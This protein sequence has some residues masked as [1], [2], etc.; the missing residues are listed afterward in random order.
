MK[1]P[2]INYLIV[3]SKESFLR[4]PL[5]VLSS[6][7]SVI[8]G[9][10]LIEF[11]D[12]IENPF[13]YINLLL[14]TA[15]GIPLYFCVSIFITKKN[16]DFKL[17][18]AS[19]TLG[20]TIL[21]LIY[22]SLPDSE[23]T[24]NTSLPYIRYGLYNII[25]HLL[26]S[27][28]PYAKDMELNGFWNYNKIL[29]IRFWT[30]LLYSGFL[31][32]GITLALVSL[33]ILFNIEIPN[34]LYFKIS[35]FILGFFNTWF[36]V[37]GIPKE[38]DNLEN[39]KEYPEGLKVFTQYILLP[40]L[41]L[42]LVILYT[43][44]AKILISWDW[45]KG[46]V[47]YLISCVSIL[48]ILTL[49]L[50]HPYGNLKE[51]SWVKKFTN[52]YYYI[53]FPL[54]IILFIAIWFRINDYGITINRYVIILLGVWLSIISFYFSIRKTNIKFIPISL[55]IILFLMSFGPWSM[56]SISENSQVNRLKE[57]LKKNSIVT[58]NRINNEVLWETDSLPK[59]HSIIKETNENLLNDS[60]HNEIKSILDYLD[61]HHGFSKIRSLFN[62]N[63]DSLIKI[64]LD[65]NKNIN[66][67]KIYMNTI[68]LKY[69]HK[70]S[71]K[72]SSYITYSSVKKN[73][74]PI[75]DYDYLLYFN[76][77]DNK[78]IFHKQTFVT[79]N[80]QHTFT[81][82]NKNKLIL[83]SKNDT[84]NFNL[85]RVVNGLKNEFGI[86]GKS[87]VSISKMTIKDESS[88]FNI[89]I[90]FKS[91]NL[92]LVN[93]STSIKSIRGSLFLKNNI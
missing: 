11:I 51:N 28:I 25:I 50:L 43:Y 36:F 83:I 17:R 80:Q 79:N 38:L 73:I 18:L 4:F 29:F 67:A 8:I 78:P 86:N 23:T 5:T 22:F 42:Y 61:D 62:Q 3:K 33:N 75:S 6:L 56:F 66:E 88:F 45:P 82:N 30:S 77:N 1:L 69:K 34:K 90:E 65:K 39:I 48:G 35:V 9:V 27:F 32:I 93:D 84:I 19:Q 46:I 26:V 31:Y 58:K 20:T 7:I 59:F 10:Y 92:E 13:P 16:Y 44:G 14:T 60:T 54:I 91:I 76:H 47:S 63:I 85:N 68:G 87:D 72:N 52:I 89:K 37:S 49:L 64:S 21:I 24:H 81:Y 41:I 71:Y 74:I 70:Y 15:L 55:S 57:I 40:L 2:S 12:D 53:L